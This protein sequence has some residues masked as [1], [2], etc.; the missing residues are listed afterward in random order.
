MEP[1]KDR[2]FKNDLQPQKK[3]HQKGSCSGNILCF[4]TRAYIKPEFSHVKKVPVVW[5]GSPR[6]LVQN[7]QLPVHAGPRCQIPKERKC[8]VDLKGSKHFFSR[9][10]SRSRL[11]D[12]STRWFS[13]FTDE[14]AFLR[15]GELGHVGTL[16]DAQNS[17]TKRKHSQ[18]HGTDVTILTTGREM[19]KN[20]NVLCPARTP[21][22]THDTH[23]PKH[24]WHTRNAAIKC[25]VAMAA[26]AHKTSK[27]S[28]VKK[29][30]SDKPGTTRAW[31]G[32]DFPRNKRSL[33]DQ[34]QR[35]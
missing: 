23:Q 14:C 6:I 12:S 8:W 15:D 22:N 4:S 21:K 27:S 1:N 24:L 25:Q 19:S 17:Q 10:H 3:K 34:W 16:L 35:P 7:H 31:P 33:E 11:V 9:K 32:K 5:F 30:A 13:G 26:K 2:V 28:E 20:L 29:E 18:P